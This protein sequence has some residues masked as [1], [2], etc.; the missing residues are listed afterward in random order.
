MSNANAPC[1]G[2]IEV[3]SHSVIVK[4]SEGSYTLKLFDHLLLRVCVETSRAHGLTLSLK[5]LQCKPIDLENSFSS[6]DKREATKN[7][8]KVRSEFTFL[9]VHH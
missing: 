8:V 4:Y 1:T 3:G 6:E 9:R 7:L 5:I 2:G